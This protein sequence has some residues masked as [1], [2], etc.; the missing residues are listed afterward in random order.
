MS[1]A[2]L[3]LGRP[4]I[5]LLLECLES[6]SAVISGAVLQ[7]YPAEAALLKEAHFIKPA[8]HEPVAASL[9]DGSDTPI[10]LV[11]S[12]EE[13]GYGY[14]SE[15]SGWVSVP[16]EDLVIWAVDV[17]A[18]IAALART[19]QLP[20][21]PPAMIV[22]Q[23]LWDLGTGRLGNRPKRTPIMFAR[24]LADT[25]TWQTVRLAISNRPSLQRRLI[26]TSTSSHLLPDPPSGCVIVSIGDL[27]PPDGNPEIDDDVL[28]LL[29]DR[30][31]TA[32]PKGPIEV[33]A[34]GKEVRFFGET[35][36]FRRGG[37]QREIICLLY[38]R[39]LNDELWVSSEE[40]IEELE[41]GPKARIRDY[42]K[43]NAAW[44]KLLTERDGMCGFCFELHR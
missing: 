10:S 28:S 17:G 2:A 7:R 18:L 9:D 20:A 12:P 31:P 5:K 30:V 42:F 24:R 6:P 27:I 36:K 14:F 40:I 41:L 26:L 34:D 32:H 35:Y 33:F 21:K 3:R 13:R 25:L 19:L 38:K 4:A 44:K 1:S 23:S 43:R 39:Y 16:Q 8:G 29:L 37:R 15:I 11:W 22:E